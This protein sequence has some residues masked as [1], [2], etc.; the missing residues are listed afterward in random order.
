[1]T[2]QLDENSLLTL[3]FSAAFIGALCG[4]VLGFGWASLVV[5]PRPVRRPRSSRRRSRRGVWS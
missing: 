3:V 2:W 5:R 1:M 4:L